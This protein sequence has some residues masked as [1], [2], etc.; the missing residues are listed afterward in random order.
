MNV[1]LYI[2][3]RWRRGFRLA[4][5]GPNEARVFFDLGVAS[6]AMLVAV[7]FSWLSWPTLR[8]PGFGTWLLPMLFVGATSAVGMYTRLKTASSQV[9]VAALT[10][11]VVLAGVAAWLAGG[12]PVV[13][14]LWAAATLP[15]VT[16]A[17]VLLGLPY[18]RHPSLTHLAVNSH[19]PVLVLGGAGYIGSLTVELLLKRGHR[20]RV[21]DRLMYGPQAL[22]PF[23]GHPNFE[24][25]KG[26]ATEI[27][28]LTAATRDASA[29]IQLAG[30]VGDPACAIDPAFTRHA[31]IVATR[32]S[33]EVAQSLGVSRFIFASSCSV[34]GASDRKVRE[35]DPLNPV[36]L[37]AQ[38]KIDSEHE[39]L[40]GTRDEFY[41]TVLRFATVFGHSRRPR[42]DLVANL[43]TAQA[44][45]Q[46][47][48]RVI[49]P[50]QWRPFIHVNDLA[51]ALV[52][53]LE[54]EPEQI[55][56]QVFNV[57]DDRLNLTIGQLGEAVCAAVRPFR[58]VEVVVSNDVQDRRNY[59]VAFDKIHE[60]LGFRA[61]ILVEDGLR[62]MVDQL[63]SG[64][65]GDVW[66]PVY[67]NVATTQ[68]ALHEF[69]SL[70]ESGRL[71]APLG[72]RGHQGSIKE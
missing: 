36:S 51:R 72:G 25:I 45:T 65:Y 43:F 20:V 39:L 12:N 22:E 15:T 56:S 52:M 64:A 60:T 71:Y 47:R 44:M 9:K 42:F 11:A 31:N 35:G 1:H 50:D 19:G 18:S 29:V 23:V 14:G 53:T 30:L 4:T 8:G 24:F 48:I 5:L 69:Y 68:A 55:Q 7:L 46:G 34:Y 26:D 2:R 63:R 38:T 67:S 58:E 16:S 3:S 66:D 59:N 49:G 40:F 70:S 6:W 27:S 17:R 57:G 33:K 61:E 37:Y 28:K 41:V 10:A 13:L 21:L 32:M 54:A 62:E